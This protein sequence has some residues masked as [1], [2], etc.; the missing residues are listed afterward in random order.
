LWASLDMAGERQRDSCQAIE[1]IPLATRKAIFYPKF[2]CE[3]NN[4]EYYW[5]ALKRYTRENCTYRFFELEKTVR[6]AMDSVS[7]KT[8]RRFADRSKRWTMAYINGLSKEQREF[9]EKEY[10]QI[11]V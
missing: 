11:F 7:L 9:A 1:S 8:I 5:A 2:H 10:R 6:N 3:L 4:I